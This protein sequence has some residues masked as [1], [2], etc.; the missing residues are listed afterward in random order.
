MFATIF[1][2]L[3]SAI[4]MFALLDRPKPIDTKEI[5]AL[6]KFAQAFDEKSK[7]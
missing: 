2:T 6:K 5:E 4:P 7:R 3:I 1:L